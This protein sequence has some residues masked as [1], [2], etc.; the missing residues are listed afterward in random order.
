LFIRELAKI[1]AAA[2]DDVPDVAAVVVEE[3]VTTVLVAS[4]T[5]S[6]KETVEVE[7]TSIVQVEKKISKEKK[8]VNPPREKKAKS[9]LPNQ[10]G[11]EKKLAPKEKKPKKMPKAAN[12][13]AAAHPSY[14]LVL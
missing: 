4:G 14:L 2:T 3:R 13:P 9:S 12:G 7:S 5:E 8:R 6:E 1:M 10:E 11:R